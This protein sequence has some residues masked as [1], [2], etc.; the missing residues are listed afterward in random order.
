M[1]SPEIEYLLTDLTFAAIYFLLAAISVAGSFAT[2]RALS[3]ATSPCC[4][5]PRPS[6]LGG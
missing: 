3:D 1:I 4:P 6:K 2:S 5:P